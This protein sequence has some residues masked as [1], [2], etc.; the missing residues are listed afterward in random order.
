[1]GMANISGLADDSLASISATPAF[2][3]GQEKSVQASLQT[4][5]VDSEFTTS[6]G[7]RAS[8]DNG[9]GLIPDIG[10]VIPLESDNWTLG[11]G[12]TVHSGMLASFDFTDTPGTLGVTYGR[13][14]HESQYSV[15]NAS[16]ALAYQLN[17]NLS[18]GAQ[19]GLAYNRN[20]L[21]ALYI[22]QS[23][24]ALAGLKV[25]VDLERLDK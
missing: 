1:M 2:L 9:P 15:V 4:I 13:Q 25:L 5:W 18:L 14:T 3:S 6:L 23:H 10:F 21:L 19:M 11:G 8:A 17:D 16:L 12:V 24:P 22:F 20:Q 7:E